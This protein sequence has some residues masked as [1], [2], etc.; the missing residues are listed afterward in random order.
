MA[1]KTVIRPI[2][3]ESYIP[4]LDNT[5][6]SISSSPKESDRFGSWRNSESYFP[7]FASCSEVAASSFVVVQRSFLAHDNDFPAF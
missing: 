7:L 1:P 4:G 3:L 6:V 2:A 5:A